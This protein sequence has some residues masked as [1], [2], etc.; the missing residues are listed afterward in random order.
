MQKIARRPSTATCDACGGTVHL[1]RC[2]VDEHGRF[3]TRR[4]RLAGACN[5]RVYIH[6]DTGGIE[7]DE[8][9]TASTAP[10]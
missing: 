8:A 7:C 2:G 5:G 3:V 1:S 9:L 6:A 4:E 10:R